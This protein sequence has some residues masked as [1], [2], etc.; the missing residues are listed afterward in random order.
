MN[1]TAQ[2]L[3]VAIIGAGTMGAA[4]ARGVA[5][6]HPEIALAVSNRTEGKLRALAGE[7]PAATLTTSNAEAARGAALIILAVKPW[8]LAAVAAEIAPAAREAGATVASLLGGVSLAQL[9]E[10]LPGCPLM[11]VIPN[12]AMQAGKSMTFVA[13][14]AEAQPSVPLVTDIFSSMGA[15][16]VIEERLMDAA[17]ALSSC[18]IAYCYK[19]AQALTQAGVQMGF[20]AA[21]AL[22]YAAATMAG[23]AAMLQAPGA[24]AQGEIDKVTTPGGMTIRGINALERG[25]FPAA[26]IEAVLEP[27]K[28]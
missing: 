25:G 23:A 24:S 21:D 3:K 14:T 1:P 22:R 4:I 27:L 19:F 18:G 6:H 7:L 20:T 2:P 28:K 11:R 10:A 17:T 16:A 5:A 15:V 8:M 9:S 13:A 26:V 12:T